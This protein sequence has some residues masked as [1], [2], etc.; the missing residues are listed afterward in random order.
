MESQGFV[1]GHDLVCIPRNIFGSKIQ[2]AETS[3]RGMGKCVWIFHGCVVLYSSASFCINQGVFPVIPVTVVGISHKTAPL[4]VRERFSFTN[5]EALALLESLRDYSGMTEGV[6]LSTCHRTELYMC[7][8]T[9][10]DLIESAR[11][12]LKIKAGDLVGAQNSI[13]IIF[14]V[15]RQ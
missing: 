4:P 13:S 14:R 7:P 1:V 2:S 12:A 6:V 9:D 15:F 10:Q 8:G 5:R 3:N 11:S